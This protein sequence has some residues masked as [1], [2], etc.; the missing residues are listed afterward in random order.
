MGEV[1]AIGAR[2]Q[3]VETEAAQSVAR[4]HVDTHIDSS[5]FQWVE[6]ESHLWDTRSPAVGRHG[7]TYQI[8]EDSSQY[9]N[10][11]FLSER[12]PRDQTEGA[13]RVCR[14]A[15]NG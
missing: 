2:D 3:T 1:V 8:S 4:A 14:R 12:T 13:W 5:A 10:M 11:K 7:R 9:F 6:A 15:A